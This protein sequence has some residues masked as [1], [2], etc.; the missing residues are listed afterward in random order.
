MLVESAP[1]GQTG[2]RPARLWI[3]ENQTRAARLKPTE[4]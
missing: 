4:Q 1:K 3:S 2:K